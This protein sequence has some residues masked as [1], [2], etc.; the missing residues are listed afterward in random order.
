MTSNYMFEIIY[1]LQL[2]FRC[3]N[4]CFKIV[5]GYNVSFT[6]KMCI[7]IHPHNLKVMSSL[8]NK[9]QLPLCTFGVEAKTQPLV[10]LNAHLKR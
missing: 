4:Y 2:I 6:N 9:E 3:L 8:V 7:R 1:V 10:Q 5:T